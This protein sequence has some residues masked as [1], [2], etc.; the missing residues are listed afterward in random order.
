MQ[1][2]T[3][4]CSIPYC[5][6]TLPCSIPD[7]LYTLPCSI[8]YSIT[9][10]LIPYH[11]AFKH[12]H[13]PHHAA[14]VYGSVLFH[15]AFTHCHVPYHTVFTH[16]HVLY[17]TAFTH[18]HVPFNTAFT[19]AHCPIPYHTA[20]SC[21]TPNSLYIWLCS[22]PYCLYTLPCLCVDVKCFHVFLADILVA[23]FGSPFR[24]QLSI[25]P[26]F[27]DAAILHA[28]DMTQPTQPVLSELSEH[29]WKVGSG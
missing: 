18:C 3:L 10:C 29:A 4:P 9:H 27:L 7:C 28:A 13:V 19:H 25:K 26:I 8:P 24:C 1:Y 2:Y 20:L 6:Y 21:S 12:C 11:T 16:C 23:A 5:L 15:T 22:I 14:F 17:Q